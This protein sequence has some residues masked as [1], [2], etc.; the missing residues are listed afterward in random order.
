MPV[1]GA[2]RTVKTSS[3]ATAVHIVWSS[4]G[5]SRK[6]EHLGSAHSDLEV[7]ALKVAAAKRLAGDQGELE[8]GI[9]V[10][11]DV[12]AGGDEVFR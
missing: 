10:P 1:R 9:E 4:S 7:E 6:I 11:V 8:L 12:A 2:V 3:G 5:G